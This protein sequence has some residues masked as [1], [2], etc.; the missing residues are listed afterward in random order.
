MRFTA[1]SRFRLALVA[2][3]MVVA[4]AAA[5]CGRLAGLGVV[6]VGCLRGLTPEA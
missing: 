2:P 5:G 1:L 4:A 6:I 3:G